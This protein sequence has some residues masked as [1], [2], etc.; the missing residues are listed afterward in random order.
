MIVLLAV[1][2]GV[3]PTVR[4]HTVFA[5][6]CTPEGDWQSAVLFRSHADVGQ[7]GPITRL[8]PCTPQ[9]FERYA[10]ASNR[11]R[12]VLLTNTLVYEPRSTT[13]GDV[14]AGADKPWGL[15]RWLASL[16]S[17][18]DGAAAAPQFVLVVEE[19]MVLHAA[20]TPDELG[21][22]E[23]TP[24]SASNP[25]L[26]GSGRRPGVGSTGERAGGEPGLGGAER[27]E[28]RVPSLAEQFLS[29]SAAAATEQVGGFQ[30]LSLPDLQR[31]APRW[32]Q[33][34]E[35]LRAQTHR[36]WRLPPR[37]LAR[38]GD[39]HPDDGHA[40]SGR[41]TVDIATG[42]VG[43]RRGQPTGLAEAYGYSFAAAE[44]GLSHVTRAGSL[45]I[46]GYPPEGSPL[47]V[48]YAADFAVRSAGSLADARGAEGGT[49]G[50]LPF[51]SKA[52]LRGHAIAE[53]NC[54]PLPLARPPPPKARR[55]AR[56][57]GRGLGSGRSDAPGG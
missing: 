57:R 32:L 7:P 46:A 49:A 6:S 17:G 40:A 25:V 16:P 15:M 51:F 36:Y 9:Q 41:T 21:A 35:Q 39:A 23:G 37:E 22:R 20:I 18:S 53:G 26:V 8:L 50:G 38:G 5:S 3:Q 28:R 27:R 56:A 11:T 47:L 1:C 30:L 24:A 12:A 54:G 52:Q 33:L 45:L 10:N 13:T 48:Q 2:A 55:A 4:M 34:T 14:Y 43:L 42:D 29:A 31:L 44:A 19:D